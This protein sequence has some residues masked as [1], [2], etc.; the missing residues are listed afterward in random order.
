MFTVHAFATFGEQLVFRYQ[1]G[2][3]LTVRERAYLSGYVAGLLKGREEGAAKERAHI[4]PRCAS[5]MR[6]DN[7]PDDP[8]LYCLTCGHRPRPGA[9]PLIDGG[10]HHASHGVAL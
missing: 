4:C 8:G 2:A 6:I 5:R 9:L 7:D 1:H 3:P 10:L